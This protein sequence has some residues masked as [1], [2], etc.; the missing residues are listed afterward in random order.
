MILYR[1]SH[2]LR[3]V[4]SRARG[5]RRPRLSDVHQ[6]TTKQ[7]FGSPHVSRVTEPP[8]SC[9]ETSAIQSAGAARVQAIRRVSMFRQ[10]ASQITL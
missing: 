4:P 1:P 3:L 2:A 5:R 10:A 7:R 6:C 8:C 9:S